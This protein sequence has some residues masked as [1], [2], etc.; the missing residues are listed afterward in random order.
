MDLF[1]DDVRPKL[2]LTVPLISVTTQLV[3]RHLRGLELA[4]DAFV[5][6]RPDVI[7]CHSESVLDRNVVGASVTDNAHPVNPQ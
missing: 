4:N 6:S 2:H 7:R 5:E 3:E 1:A